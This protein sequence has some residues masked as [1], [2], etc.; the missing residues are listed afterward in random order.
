MRRDAPAKGHEGSHALPDC[1]RKVFQ[2]KLAFGIVAIPGGQSRKEKKEVLALTN[3][4]NLGVSWALGLRLNAPVDSR[5]VA[6]QST[7]IPTDHLG[8]YRP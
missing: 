2:L 4:F 7:T 8:W 1:C 3:P 6:S 5:D